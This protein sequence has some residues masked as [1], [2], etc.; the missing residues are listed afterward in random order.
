MAKN[1][2]INNPCVF[3]A[4]CRTCKVVEPEDRPGLCAS[5]DCEFYIP[6]NLC[7]MNTNEVD[8]EIGNCGNATCKHLKNAQP[9]EVVETSNGRTAIEINQGPKGFQ[10]EKA[11]AKQEESNPQVS[12]GKKTRKI[13]R[14]GEPPASLSNEEKDYYLE[15]WEDY[16][17]YYRD[18][19]AYLIC[20]Q[21]IL[22]E[23][24]LSHIQTDLIETRGE[25]NAEKEKEKQKV[26]DNLSKLKQQ[27]PEKESEKLSDDEKALGR[28]YEI[29]CEEVAKHRKSGITRVLSPEAIALVPELPFRVDPE[30]M[31]RSCGYSLIEAQAAA[32]AVYTSEE[33]EK[34]GVDVL[35]FLGFKLKDH[36]ALPFDGNLDDID[37]DQF[38]DT[39][40]GLDGPTE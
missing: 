38:D 21:M 27:L 32:D 20:H 17:G 8:P 7:G 28:I 34:T 29:Y 18:P 35:T 14:P 6:C 25:A 3:K 26:Y 23:I 37:A 16:E 5:M 12:S 22:E 31:L 9:I 39:D 4:R 1:R 36:Y 11:H 15:R 2:N 40:V 13:T 10:G 33:I 19:A 24:R 30:K